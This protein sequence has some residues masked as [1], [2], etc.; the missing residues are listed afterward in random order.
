ME[1]TRR[2][3]RPSRERRKEGAEKAQRRRRE[4]TEKAQSGEKEMLQSS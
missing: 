3:D 4:G 1:D 2:T